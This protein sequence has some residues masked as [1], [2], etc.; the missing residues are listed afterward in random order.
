MCYLCAS[1]IEQDG[2]NIQRSHRQC[3]ECKLIFP[4]R[5]KLFRHLFV[6]DHYRDCFINGNVKITNLVNQIT[7]LRDQITRLDRL[8]KN[9]KILYFLVV[10]LIIIELI[11]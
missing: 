10:F 6:T 4:S 11:K 7:H 2:K 5:T 9:F 3:R 1:F 8:E